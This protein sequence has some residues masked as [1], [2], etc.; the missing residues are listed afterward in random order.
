MNLITA[1]FVLGIRVTSPELY[2]QDS[3][4]FNWKLATLVQ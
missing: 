3:L 4:L 1:L 2:C